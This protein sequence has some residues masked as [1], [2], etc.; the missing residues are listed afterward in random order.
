M[1]ARAEGGARGIPRTVSFYVRTSFAGIS[2]FDPNQRGAAV[3]QPFCT[4]SRLVC[5]GRSVGGR[6]SMDIATA[7]RLLVRGAILRRRERWGAERILGYREAQLRVL[8]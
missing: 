1:G 4:Q 6:P 2:K 7:A 3:R 8:R 5:A